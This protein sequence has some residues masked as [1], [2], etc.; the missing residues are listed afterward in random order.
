WTSAEVALNRSGGSAVG[1]NLLEAV[2]HELSRT[3]ARAV[4]FDA[5]GLSAWDSKTVVV[6]RLIERIAAVARVAVDRG[7]LPDGMQRLLAL[8]TAVQPRDKLPEPETRE[9]TVEAIGHATVAVCDVIGDLVKFLGESILALVRFACGKA[10]F[11]RSD[12]V[13]LIQDCGPKAL[14]LVGVINLFLGVILAILGA[15]RLSQLG[16][17]IYVADLVALGQT[18]EIAPMMTA[19][20][21]SGRTGAAF[22]A[23]LGTM[24]VN[25]EIDALKTFGFSPMDFLVLPRMLALG[26]MMPMLVLYADAMSIFG[27]YLV[28]VG[29]LDLGSTEYIS[30]TRGAIGLVDITLGFVKGAVFGVLVAVAGC[31]TGIQSGRSASSVGDA[32]TRAVVVGI[33]AVIVTTTLF[34][35]ATNVL[36]I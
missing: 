18:R 16:G 22:A 2:E 10:H 32:A 27:G 14:P 31:L 1:A 21:M 3:S 17:E 26:L 6:L 8:A 34:A 20:I 4:H 7:G 23:Q 19:I 24:Q 11:R 12:L 5:T 35:V 15:V 33:A 28:G 36:D 9:S 30:Q 13:L 29:L 25:E